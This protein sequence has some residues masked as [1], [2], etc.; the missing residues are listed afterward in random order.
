M[1]STQRQEE[2]RVTVSSMAEVYGPSMK[3]L[4]KVLRCN[5]KEM[6]KLAKKMSDTVILGSMEIWP[7]SAKRIE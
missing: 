6:K 5:D 3:D 4:Q 1:L 7:N 2:V